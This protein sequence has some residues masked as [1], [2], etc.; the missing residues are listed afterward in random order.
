MSSAT[1][2][3]GRAERE[4]LYRE[5]R[6]LG[7]ASAPGRLYDLG[8]YP[9]MTDPRAAGERVHGEAVLL[10]DPA[11]AF[12]WLDA[13]EGIEPDAVRDEYARVARPLRL[14]NGT[15]LIAA[16]YLYQGDLGRARHLPDGRWPGG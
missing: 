15:E 9:A 8:R 14:A 13:Y 4:R 7:P 6:S 5:G 16:V 2:R 1:G 3:L 10:G 12:P 11:A